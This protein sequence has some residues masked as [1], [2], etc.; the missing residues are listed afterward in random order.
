MVRLGQP[1]ARS[2]PE[3][4]CL[5]ARP[6]FCVGHRHHTPSCSLA[7]Q[8]ALLFRVLWLLWLLRVAGSLSGRLPW[9]LEGSEEVEEGLLPPG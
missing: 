2:L 8:M 6:P 9:N 4:A 3:G 5:M 1:R 7:C